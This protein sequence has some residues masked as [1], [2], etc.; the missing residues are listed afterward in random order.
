MENVVTILMLVAAFGMGYCARR[1]IKEG[2]CFQEKEEAVKECNQ[3]WWDEACANECG[4]KAYRAAEG[5]CFC[6]KAR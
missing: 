1:A 6:E 5:K 3:R 4:G 2:D